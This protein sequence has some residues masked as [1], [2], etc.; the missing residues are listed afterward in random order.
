MRS[1]N[2]TGHSSS[3]QKIPG[4]QAG[5]ESLPVAA[6]VASPARVPVVILQGENLREGF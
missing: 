1:S 5:G 3:V 4:S 2:S 6:V